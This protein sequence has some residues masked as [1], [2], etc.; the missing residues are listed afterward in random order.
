MSQSQ[1]LHATDSSLAV[2]AD[3]GVETFPAGERM[4]SAEVATSGALLPA[5][6]AASAPAVSVAD[7]PEG[8]SLSSLPVSSSSSTS[9]FA[10]QTGF[11]LSDPAKLMRLINRATQMRGGTVGQQQAPASAAAATLGGPG[12]GTNSSHS[13]AATDATGAAGGAQ[14]P[15]PSS[16]W[17]PRGAMDL[18]FGAKADA[19][20]GGSTAVHAAVHAAAVK[21]SGGE[22]PS[23]GL[24]PDARPPPPPAAAA[25]GPQPSSSFFNLSSFMGG[26]GEA[27]MGSSVKKP[28]SSAATSSAMRPAISGGS[29]SGGSG[30]VAGG[31]V[32]AGNGGGGGGSGQGSEG[33]MGYAS[34]AMMG[35]TEAASKVQAQASAGGRPPR[36]L[37]T[38]GAAGG[39]M[40]PLMSPSDQ[41]DA[42]SS[43]SMVSRGSY[44]A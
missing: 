39:K 9:Q 13:D 16:M 5:A 43:L 15:Q 6:A 36:P 1:A 34:R 3:D 33:L 14:P 37:N 4:A 25:A 7:E 2:R 42:F 20:M 21:G 41:D 19:A 27:A 31:S 11:V 30:S 23:L 26:I 40:R 18:H 29:S 17:L 12:S 28:A 24:L 32:S 38:S 10:F 44:S 8:G 22:P 35:L